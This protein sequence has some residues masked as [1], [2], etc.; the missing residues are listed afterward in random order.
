VAVLEGLRI[1]PAV[2][3]DGPGLVRLIALCFGQYAGCIL[4]CETE[5]TAITTPARS[6]PAFWVAE[7]TDEPGHLVG[8]VGC[9]DARGS[10]E[11]GVEL[12]KLYVDPA[13]RRCGLGRQLVELV[14]THARSL[15]ARR[16]FLWTDVRF[17]IAHRFYERLGYRRAGAPRELDDLSKTVEWP[18]AKLLTAAG[19]PGSITTRGA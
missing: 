15:A 12:K 6:F 18:Y 9:G 17:T 10:L 8:C 4:D 1:R 11:A 14:E 3:A 16:V 13:L 5:E 7:K 2:D 19:D